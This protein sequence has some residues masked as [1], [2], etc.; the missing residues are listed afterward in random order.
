MIHFMHHAPRQHRDL[1]RTLLEQHEPDK[2]DK[3][4][5]LILPSS[6]I[7]YARN[8]ARKLVAEAQEA[9]TPLPEGD[10]KAALAQAAQF[11]VDRPM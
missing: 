10:A 1:L 6:S 5:N 4:R 9:L 11:V 8:R 3:I 7:D 2:G